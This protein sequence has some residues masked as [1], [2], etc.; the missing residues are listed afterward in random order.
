M[1]LHMVL[2]V[3]RAMG[4]SV[5]WIGE[6]DSVFVKKLP[7]TAP[8]DTRRMKKDMPKWLKKFNSE[9]RIM[10]IGTSRNPANADIKTFCK[11]FER[12]I[13]I[14]KPDYATR[15]ELWKHFVTARLQ[16]LPELNPQLIKI[17][18]SSL[19]QITNGYTGGMI[20]ECVFT[21]LSERRLTNLSLNGR[22]PLN[23]EEFINSL[24]TIE[25]IFQDQEEELGKW[26]SKTPLGK[27]RVKLGKS[28]DGE[29]GD[30]G[31]KKGKK[32]KG[33][34]KK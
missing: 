13:L 10:V 1:L 9:D 30:G 5:V 21:T 15:F 23:S 32:G 33:K 14:P 11:S 26:Y 4:P 25:P 22:K 6:C 17:D 34:K 7:K 31:K 18:I 3:G 12:H 20:K 2:K 24:A 29:G 8:F 27:K 16:T 19:A 28:A